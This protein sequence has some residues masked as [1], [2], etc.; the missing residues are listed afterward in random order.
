MRLLLLIPLLA[1]S[2]QSLGQDRL[3]EIRS[4]TKLPRGI[5]KSYKAST[6]AKLN[7]TKSS[8]I[9]DLLRSGYMEASF[10]SCITADNKSSCVL[11]VGK[12]YKWAALRAGNM[13]RE[14]ASQAGFRE[15]IYRDEPISPFQLADLMEDILSYFEDNG[16]PFASVQLDS[17]E[18]STEGIRASLDVDKRFLVKLDSVVI[19]GDCKTAPILIQ[20]Q[21]G[22]NEG[23]LYNES[24][25]LQ[26]E[27]R[28]KELSFVRSKRKPYV[29]FGEKSTK[30][31]LFLEDKKAS[32]ITGI[33][34]LLPDEETGRITF[35]GD[36][37]LHLKSALNRGETIRLEWRRL[38]DQT[39]D[40]NIGFAYPYLFN[41]P[42]GLE[43]GLSI[44]RRDTS[45]LDVNSQ[46]GGTINLE[47][48]D[49]VT[50]FI[51]RSSSSR[52]GERNTV[53]ATL[54]DTRTTS[55]GLSIV[56][57]RTDYRRNPRRGHI[58]ELLGAVGNK[59]SQLVN[60]VGEEIPPAVRSLQ[61]DIRGKL[62][63][64]V[65]IGKRS[66]IRFAAQGGSMIN[67]VLFTNEL[68]RIGGFKDIRGVDDASITASSFGIGTIEYRFLFE[69]N[70]NFF[71]FMDQAWWEDQS[72]EVL[73]SDTPQAF[74]VGTN[75]ETS[76]GIFSLSYA[77][78]KQ[79]DNPIRF[80][81][82]KVHFGFASVF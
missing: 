22:I 20:E 13:N 23:D 58:L 42:F 6:N 49:Q 76:S 47:D 29:L 72:A 52:L 4:H 46:I 51:R 53:S 43:A 73:I 2:L 5:N 77:L 66:T 16:Y 67:E 79:F 82:A 55:Y 36:L 44:Y 60:P 63:G 37:D 45:F 12:Q 11:H 59:S 74:G 32:S 27:K 64:H 21:I 41:T 68:F 8:I 33:V 34:G 57:D 19:K 28:L 80:N 54:A 30:L 78:G 24:K 3:L 48:G 31:Y 15:K 75:F 56:R 10:D 70:S 69:E 25:I 81:S 7:R 61:Y 38:Q 26:I 39:Q 18:E 50:A 9:N 35:T 1:L 62:V 40:L 65:A 14:I 17:L 71:L